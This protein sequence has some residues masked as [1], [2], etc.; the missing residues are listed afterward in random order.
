MES[1]QIESIKIYVRLCTGRFDTKKFFSTSV[2]ESEIYVKNSRKKFAKKCCRKILSKCRNSLSK[3]CVEKCCQNFL[4]NFSVEKNCRI[5]LS[6]KTVK[7]FCRIPEK[8]CRKKMSKIAV[9]MSKNSVGFSAPL[10]RMFGG[11]RIFSQKKFRIPLYSNSD[12]KKSLALFCS[13][14]IFFKKT[15]QKPLYSNSESRKSLAYFSFV[16]TDLT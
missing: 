15:F 1:F 12:L 10:M 14:R 9:E 7:K 4:S 8:C 3:T 2:V 11:E 6:K 13:G 16:R 5:F